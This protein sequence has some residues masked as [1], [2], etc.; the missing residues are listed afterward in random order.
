MG[1][2]ARPRTP[3]ASEL[4]HRW[5]EP[6][7]RA[8]R[9]LY[10]EGKQA[11][12]AVGEFEAD[13]FGQLRAAPVHAGGVEHWADEFELAIDHHLRGSVS[14]WTQARLEAELRRFAAGCDVFPTYAEFRRTG[15]GGL[16]TGLRRH[17]GLDVW[18]ARMG[19]ARRARCSGRASVA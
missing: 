11:W 12:L 13:G 8:T 9:T 18:A 3:Q 7:V 10:R 15:H 4:R 16:L 19:L 1:Q 17:G 2:A 14:Y 6:R 5:T